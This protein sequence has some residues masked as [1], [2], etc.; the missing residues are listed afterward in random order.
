MFY[1]SYPSSI[2]II[3]LIT[4]LSLPRQM[5]ESNDLII[6]LKDVTFEHMHQIFFHRNGDFLDLILH[7]E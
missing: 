7:R 5:Q 4:L 3:T 6:I 2:N 1:T